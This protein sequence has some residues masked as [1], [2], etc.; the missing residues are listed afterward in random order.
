M[1]ESY[2]PR[3]TEAATLLPVLR[4]HL[5]AAAA[6][7][8]LPASTLE[9]LPIVDDGLFGYELALEPEPR[10]TPMIG[11]DAH[12]TPHVRMSSTR[13]AGGPLRLAAID[14]ANTDRLPLGWHRV[15]REGTPYPDWPAAATALWSRVATSLPEVPP[16]PLAFNESPHRH[17]DVA[18][19]IAHSYLAAWDVRI[20][21]FGLPD[22]AQLGFELEAPGGGQGKLFAQRTDIWMLRWKCAEKAV[23][24]EWSVVLPEQ[25]G[26]GGVTR[27]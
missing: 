14:G 9:L 27:A 2:C 22:E 11:C 15:R 4:A 25:L 12:G 7:N 1:A 3:L 20:R 17:L 21:F 24:E 23:Y 10:A 16:Q 18:L 8:P 19:A 13:D 26:A 5:L 6:R